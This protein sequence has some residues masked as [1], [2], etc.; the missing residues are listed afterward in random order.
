MLPPTTPAQRARLYKDVDDLISPGFLSHSLRVGPT[1]FVLRTLGPGDLFLLRH[2][3]GDDLVDWQ[4]WA[5]ATSIWMVNGRCILDEPHLAPRLFMM[6]QALP[7][8]A[9]G[10]LFSTFLGLLNRMKRAEDAIE[11]FMYETGSRLKWQALG[12]DIKNLHLG[13]P[14]AERLGMNLLQQIWVTFNRAEDVR[15]DF[16]NQWEGFKLVASSNSPKG[17]RKIDQKD[18]QRKK[19]EDKRRQSVMDRYFYY[20]VGVVDREGYLKH[21]DRDLVGSK[22][23]PTKTVEELEDEMKRWV[24]GEFDEHD[25]IVEGYKQRILARQA[26]VEAE[27]EERRRQLAAEAERR[28]NEGFEPT[29]LIGLTQEQLARILAERDRGRPSGARTVYDDDFFR[30]KQAVD[31]HIRR[32]DSGRLQVQD[33]RLVDPRFNPEGYQRSLQEMIE[34]RQ[35][36]YSDQPP[37]QPAP[38]GPPGQRGPRPAHIS[39]GDW[40]EYGEKVNPAVFGGQGRDD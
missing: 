13:V 10:V 11:P 1:T 8:R 15:L 30:S 33:G 18:A 5:V 2:R 37:Q 31:K 22:L 9:L 4:A 19:D 38:P 20:R 14:G 23:V 40:E 27:R 12:G 32:P 6:L 24:S 36:G 39:E 26:E 7:R 25:R 17:V 29:P 16:E 34:D 35:V 28:A 3:T 21:R